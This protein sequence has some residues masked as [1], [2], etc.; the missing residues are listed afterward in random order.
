[1]ITIPNLKLGIFH[2]LQSNP[3]TAQQKIMRMC[4]FVDEDTIAEI[5]IT[6]YEGTVDAD[7]VEKAINP[8]NKQKIN[9]LNYR[10]YV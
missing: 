1:M 2:Q 4:N 8:F 7:W 10:T 5:Y 9:Y 3:E 6:A